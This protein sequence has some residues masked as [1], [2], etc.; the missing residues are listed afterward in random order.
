MSVSARL[1]PHLV[2]V[3]EG[4]NAPVDAL[5][6]RHIR[7]ARHVYDPGERQ[8]GVLTMGIVLPC[9]GTGLVASAA[10]HCVS[11][12]ERVVL[13]I[14][15]MRSGNVCARPRPELRAR[16]CAARQLRG[17]RHHRTRRGRHFQDDFP[18]LLAGKAGG[19][20]RSGLHVRST[21]KENTS[22]VLLTALRAAGLP[23]ARFGTKDGEISEGTSALEA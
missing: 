3:G 16:A 19:R 14:A 11:G 4:V 21:T 17:A 13:S 18:I 9:R 12:C 5:G 23:L 10:S 22:K 6:S 8:R 20:L 15:C 1:L 7:P 2:P